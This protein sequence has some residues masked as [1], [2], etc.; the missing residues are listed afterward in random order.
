MVDRYFQCYKCHYHNNFYDIPFHIKGKKCKK[1]HSFNIFKYHKKNQRNNFG[2]I[3][4]KQF[5]K[6]PKKQGNRLRNINH[7][8]NINL[9]NDNSYSLIPSSII[10]NNTN[11]ILLNNN[12]NNLYEDDN[13][14]YNYNHN[15]NDNNNDEPFSYDNPSNHISELNYHIQFNFNSLN[16]INQINNN[17]NNNVELVDNNINKISWLK[18]ESAG[19]SFIKKYG[20]DCTCSICLETIKLKEDINITKCNHIFHYECIEKSINEHGL[21]CPNCR[22]N[23]KDGSK[24]SIDNYLYY[25]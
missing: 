10:N 17:I 15:Y 18:K 5:F 19:K 6:P 12:N 1:C 25:K 4:K 9:Y 16:Q 22:S 2:H 20:K 8:N 23:L 24:K 3:I 7:F 13:F 14:N 21:D 11:N